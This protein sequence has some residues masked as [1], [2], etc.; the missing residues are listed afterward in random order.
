MDIRD[1]VL[2]CVHY[3]DL[4]FTTFKAMSIHLAKMVFLFACLSL[5]AHK[6]MGRVCEAAEHPEKAIVHYRR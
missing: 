2:P 5:S 4:S 3:L 1:G 6:F